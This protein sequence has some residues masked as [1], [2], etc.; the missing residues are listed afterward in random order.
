M[1]KIC[2]KYPRNMHKICFHMNVIGRRFAT[3]YYHDCSGRIP[4]HTSRAPQV[5]FELETN[6]FQFYAIANLDKTSLYAVICYKKAV[7]CTKY[8]QN[9]KYMYCI[10]QICKRYARNMS[11]ICTNMLLLYAYYMLLY[12]IKSSCSKYT[13]I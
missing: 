9:C 2:T 10:S 6:C 11:E 7:I 13:N 1:Q 12:A 5:G 4:G 3:A 8:A